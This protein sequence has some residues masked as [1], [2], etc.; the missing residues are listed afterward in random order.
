MSQT[1]FTTK[2]S[3]I[4]TFRPPQ[5]GDA[6]QLLTY[7]NGLVAENAQILM[8]QKQD[9]AGEAQYLQDT[10]QK[11][12]D[13]KK[14]QLLAFHN[15]TLI[16]SCQVDKGQYRTTHVGTYGISIK[17]GYRHEGLGSKLSQLVLDQAQK[18]LGIT[19]VKLDVFP[20]NQPAITLYKKLGFKQYGQLPQGI[21][22]QD[23]LVDHIF[24]YKPL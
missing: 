19:L 1:T 16:G 9:A 10:L 13:R 22:Y 4:I 8:N 5:P 24:M 18:E 3:K 17:A 7:I 2:S 21:I 12:A 6:P 11:I 20:T 14:V 15:N 23:K